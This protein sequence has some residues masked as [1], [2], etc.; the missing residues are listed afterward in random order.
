MVAH[1]AVLRSADPGLVRRSVGYRL[2]HGSLVVD[3]AWHPGAPLHFFADDYPTIAITPDPRPLGEPEAGGAG[4]ALV[5]PTI[6][7]QVGRLPLADAGVDCVL[8]LD[9]VGGAVGE[10]GTLVEIRRVLRPGGLVVLSATST[11]DR[12]IG[13]DL[14]FPRRQEAVGHVV[15]AL[16]DLGLMP[17]QVTHLQP[18]MRPRALLSRIQARA[19]SG[20]VAGL[21]EHAGTPFACRV[22][23]A[24]NRFDW[25]RSGHRRRSRASWVLVF[26]RKP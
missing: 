7:A 23:S 3:V 24:V 11:E 20:R 13:R 14:G 15:T 8:L 26:A 21:T 18:V 5:L 25:A 4:P 22:V 10:L 1:P 2:P 12:P 9:P 16:T 19:R 17:E 6:R